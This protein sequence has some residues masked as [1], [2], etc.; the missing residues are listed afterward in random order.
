MFGAV[1][2]SVG[3]WRGGGARTLRVYRAA[4]KQKHEYFKG[5]CK[6]DP[7]CVIWGDFFTTLSYDAEYERF[8]YL[9]YVA[10]I[11]VGGGWMSD[12]D[13]L[14][15]LLGVSVFFRGLE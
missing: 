1:L 7:K 3:L 11:E 10:M 4:H 15:M 2:A 8:C 9:R 14:P 12:I 6:I 13:T 5:G